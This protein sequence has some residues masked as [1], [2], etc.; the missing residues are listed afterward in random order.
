V[1]TYPERSGEPAHDGSAG[2]TTAHAPTT[3]P[4]RPAADPAPRPN[5]DYTTA[6][7][8]GHDELY[9]TITLDRPD[10]L[11]AIT[12]DVISELDAAFTRA[13]RNPA[14][15]I[16]FVTGRG[17]GFSAGGDLKSYVTLQ[18][19][20]VRFPRF[21]EELHATFARIRALRVPVVALVNGITAAGGL[22]LLLSCDLSIA[23]ESAK[24]GD[25]HLN[26]GQM[27]G[28]GVL[29]ML[30]RIIGLPRAMELVMTGRFLSA[31]VAEEWGLVG[32]VVPDDELVDN[33]IALAQQIAVKSPLAVANAKSVMNTIWSQ[34]L[35]V[36]S[37]LELERARNSLYCLTSYDA[38]EGLLAFGE[39]RAPRFEGR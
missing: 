34:C 37:G 33:A 28:G 15:R 3:R 36:P 26:F 31:A 32:S 13:E 6:V 30:P 25:G 1:G 9:A 35:S 24:I 17:R 5:V 8:P 7:I 4:L 22:E 20:P 27:G 2:V 29:T 21:V 38:P 11:N 39:K 10:Q 18:R 19:D 12:S 16:V 23:A 14:V